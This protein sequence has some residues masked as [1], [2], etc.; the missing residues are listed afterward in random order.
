LHLESNAF[1]PVASVVKEADVIVLAGDV[2]P[3]VDGIVWARQAFGDKPLV[4]VAGN[5]ELYE[6]DWNRT[7]D[8]M[9]VA[10]RANHVYFLENDSVVID[11]VSFFGAT[12][13]TD[14][15]YFST[16]PVWDREFAEKNFPDFNSIW[17]GDETL[18]TEQTIARHNESLAWLKDE[19][20]KGDPE[21][22]VV[23]THH[24]PHKKS[25]APQYVVDRLTAVFGSHIPESVINQCGLW[26]HGHTHSSSNYRIG[27]GERY[28]RVIANPRGFLASY[29]DY[30]DENPSFDPKLIVESL[31]DGNWGVAERRAVDEDWL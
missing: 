28:T 18:T 27:G 17:V 13:W 3:G 5:H 22:Q 20:A 26:I 2:H 25:C 11:G 1:S 14:F 7:L 31:P 23:V 8:E 24:F 6:G 10:A 4:M 30:D 29:W 21:K 9:R 19:L 16:T 15:Q 12:L